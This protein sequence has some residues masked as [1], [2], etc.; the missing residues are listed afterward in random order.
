MGLLKKLFKSVAKPEINKLKGKV[1]ESKVNSELNP[2]LFG[3]VNIN[4]L[5]I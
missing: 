3:R 5:I 2:W 4:K 1:G